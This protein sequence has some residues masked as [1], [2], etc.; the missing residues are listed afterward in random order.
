MFWNC[1]ELSLRSL[2]LTITGIVF[3]FLV[4]STVQ[5]TWVLL[6]IT[7]RVTRVKQHSCDAATKRAFK[8]ASRTVRV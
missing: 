3:R 5:V 1:G 6:Y 4:R 2:T 7:V 8:A